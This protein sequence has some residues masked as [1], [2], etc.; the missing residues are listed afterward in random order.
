MKSLITIGDFIIVDSDEAPHKIPR[1]TPLQVIAVEPRPSPQDKVWKE[2]PDEIYESGEAFFVI[3]SVEIRG[4]NISK[5]LA[6]VRQSHCEKY[7]KKPVINID[8]NQNYFVTQEEDDF[9]DD[10]IFFESE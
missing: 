5:G 9:E 8:E 7:N 4:G 10:S 1:G 6:F 3:E 2:C